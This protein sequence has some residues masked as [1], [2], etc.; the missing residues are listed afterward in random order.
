VKIFTELKRFGVA[1]VFD[2]ES[3]TGMKF[4]QTFSAA[5]AAEEICKHLRKLLAVK[6]QR[7]NCD[8]QRQLEPV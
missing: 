6:N 8:D 5:V 2:I 1:D 7:S 4:S 3:C